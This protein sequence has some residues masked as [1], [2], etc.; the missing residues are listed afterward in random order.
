MQVGSHVESRNDRDV[1][2]VG[3]DGLAHQEERN[4][5]IVQF[6]PLTSRGWSVCGSGHRSVLRHG[7][8]FV[9]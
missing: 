1:V 3:W 5:A 8:S 4:A 2:S 9:R 7:E 6:R